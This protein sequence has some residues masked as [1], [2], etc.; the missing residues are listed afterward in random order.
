VSDLRF[1]RRRFMAVTGASAAAS[2][3][4]AS[5]AAGRADAAVPDVARGGARPFADAVLAAFKQHQLVGV[6]ETHTQ[7][8]HGDAL[9]MLLADPRLPQVV[10]DVVVEFGNS[11]YQP[12]MDRFT[13]GAAVNNPELRQIWRNGVASPVATNDEP[14]RE[15]FYRTVR[16]VNWTL[17]PDQRI[18]VLLGEPPIDWPQ[19]TTNDQVQAFADQRDTYLASL[20]EREVLAKGRRALIFYGSEH[21]MHSPGPG[22]NEGHAVPIIEQQTGQ[23]VYVM[24]AGSHPRLASYPRRTVIPCAG[25]WLESADAGE[26]AYSPP[27]CGFPLGGLADAVLYLGQLKDLTQSLWNPAIY[28]DPLWWAELQRRNAIVGNPIDLEQYRQ[29]QPINWPVP[30]PVSCPAPAS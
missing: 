1:T 28:L 24:V 11:L 30:A 4:L 23:H 13:A 21:V 8:E 10:N 6:G 20:V 16:A 3:M 5:W 12:V 18:R 9:Q 2:G 7:Q 29:E 26:F 17:P 22:Q 14:I 15:Q 25:T 19:I 27:L